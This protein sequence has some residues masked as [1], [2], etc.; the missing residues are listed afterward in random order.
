MTLLK[1]Q[2]HTNHQV[3]ILIK[4]HHSHYSLCVLLLIEQILKR[5]ERSSFSDQEQQTGAAN[6]IQPDEYVHV[7]VNLNLILF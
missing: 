6:V 2:D 3:L 1:N 5:T 7:H 4:E